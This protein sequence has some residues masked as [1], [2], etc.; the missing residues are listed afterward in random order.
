MGRWNARA[1]TPWKDQPAKYDDYQ[2]V[3]LR[4]V[5]VDRLRIVVVP[6]GPLPEGH[7]GA[8]K[9]AWLFLDEIVFQ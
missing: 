6:Y 9:P 4:R 5:K 3:V 1:G 2:R 7:P 8:G